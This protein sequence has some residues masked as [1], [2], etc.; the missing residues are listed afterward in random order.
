MRSL[1][2]KLKG[3]PAARRR[4][5]E[6]RAKDLIAEEMTLQ[7]LRRARKITQVRMAKELG[8]RQDGVSRL[9]KRTDLMLS[10]LRKT[11]AAMGGDLSLVASFPD[12]E[13]VVLSGI[14]EAEAK[15][16]STFRRRIRRR[17][18]LRSGSGPRGR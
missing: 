4:K 17:N 14:G 12:R 16:P 7:E 3:I 9:E 5:I 10:T 1:E 11:V 6:K 8:I 2:E 13:P 15:S 18:N